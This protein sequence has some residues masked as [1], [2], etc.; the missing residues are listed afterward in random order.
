MVI[1]TLVKYLREIIQGAIR[2]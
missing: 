1:S 2:K